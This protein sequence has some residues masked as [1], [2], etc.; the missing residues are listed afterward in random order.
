MREVQKGMKSQRLPR[1]AHQPAAGIRRSRISIA[2]LREI[3]AA[4]KTCMTG[5]DE[6][7]DLVIVGSGGGSM[8]A[9]LAS[10][11][12]GKRALIIEKQPLVG[13]STGFSG[14]V[15]WIPNNPVMKRAGVDDSPSARV[16]TSMRR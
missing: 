9:A 13:G 11:T 14:G 7:Y 1:R 5:W 15:W 16:S 12:L 2:C 4:A 8:C 6:T 10:K 3:P